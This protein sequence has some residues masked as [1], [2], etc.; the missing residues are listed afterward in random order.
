[1]TY[2]SPLELPKDIQTLAFATGSLDDGIGNRKYGIGGYGE[3]RTEVYKGLDTHEG[4]T[5]HMGDDL[6]APA[7]APVFAAADGKIFSFTDNDKP[8]D[9]GP[10]LILEHQLEDGKIIYALYGH[11]SRSSLEGKKAGQAVRAR[12]KIA[13][14]GDKTVNGNWTPHV[15]FQLCWEAPEVCDMPGIVAPEDFAEAKMIYPRPRSV[16]GDI[17]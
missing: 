15:H 11:L 10:T 5:V 12:E 4:R 7:G 3:N 2:Y 14:V 1:M 8:G 16:F 9:Y 13:E 17:Y 6:F